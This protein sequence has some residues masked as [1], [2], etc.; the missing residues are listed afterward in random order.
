MQQ[1]N[2]KNAQLV[3]IAVIRTRNLLNMSLL[4]QPLDRAS[5]PLYN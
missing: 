3:S 5:R 4:R 1:I 2:V